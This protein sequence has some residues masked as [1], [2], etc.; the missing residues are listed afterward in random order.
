MKEVRCVSILFVCS[1][2][3][4]LEKCLILILRFSRRCVTVYIYPKLCDNV[5]RD[6]VLFVSY[7]FSFKIRRRLP[8]NTARRVSEIL[9]A[10]GN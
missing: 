4:L 7:Q 8:R 2:G 5:I 9:A 3:R 1:G 10:Q 6:E